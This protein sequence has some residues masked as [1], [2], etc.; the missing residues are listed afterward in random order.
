MF[1][2]KPNFTVKL[3]Q[4]FSLTSVRSRSHSWWQ[5]YGL[6]C[7][8]SFLRLLHFMGGD[9]IGR[10]LSLAWLHFRCCFGHGVSMM[11]VVGLPESFLSWSQKEC[12][13]LC[14]LINSSVYLFA[15]TGTWP[16]SCLSG[17]DALLLWN[18]FFPKCLDVS[19]VLTSVLRAGRGKLS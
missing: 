12:T 7:K 1:D 2:A 15:H 11:H 4:I 18:W 16:A 14:R 19:L 17:G 8:K 5:L 9:C 3:T 10:P 13:D 6:C